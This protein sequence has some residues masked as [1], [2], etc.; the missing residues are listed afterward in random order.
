ML[1]L[2]ARGSKEK[3][4]QQPFVLLGHKPSIAAKQ[5][6]ATAEGRGRIIRGCEWAR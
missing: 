6:A 3:S 2:G 5:L 4:N 1:I